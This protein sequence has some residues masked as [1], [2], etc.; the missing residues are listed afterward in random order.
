MC[1][2]ITAIVPTESNIETLRHVI[3]K[4]G[5]EFTPLTNNFI[6]SQLPPQSQYYRATGS[7]CDCDDSFGYSFHYNRTPNPI[8]ITKHMTRLRKKGW[9]EAKIQRS[10][11][12]KTLAREK[13]RPGIPESSDKWIKFL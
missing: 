10:I 12:E 13:P 11:Q 3:K 6:S 1:Y 7:Y 5:F 2:F 9:N 4:H 8:D